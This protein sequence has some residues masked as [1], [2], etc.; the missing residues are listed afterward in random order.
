M[1]MSY[2]CMML[3]MKEL[4]SRPGPAASILDALLVVVAEHGLERATVREVAG[5]AAVAIG[6]VQHYFPTKDDLVSAAFTEVVR[7]IETRVQA[8]PLGP[9]PHANL[10]ALLQ[11]LLPLDDRRRREARI[12]LAFAAKAT[13]SPALAAVQRAALDDVRRALATAF[14]AAW[15]QPAEAPRC[16]LAATAALAAVDGLALHAVSADVDGKGGHLVETLE[17]V[18]NA[19][20]NAP[21][22]ALPAQPSAS[23]APRTKLARR[24]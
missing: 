23:N 21:A 12:Q 2:G 13:T 5:A 16:V 11:E 22:E 4:S 8:I 17:L 19:L 10:H 24:R 1:S 15:A 14:G 7:H 18:L 6:T 9:D 20:L 3:A